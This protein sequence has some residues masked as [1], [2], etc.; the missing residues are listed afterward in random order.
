MRNSEGYY[1]LIDFWNSDFVRW[2][3]EEKIPRS[4]KTCQFPE[5]CNFYYNFGLQDLK[6]LCNLYLFQPG[7]AVVKLPWWLS[8][9]ESPSMQETWVWSLGWDNPLEKEMTTHS[10][11]AWRIPCTEETGRLQSVGSQKSGTQLSD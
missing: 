5:V 10:S 2:F 6:M 1:G 3:S 9:K 7:T 4:G 8:G 11:I